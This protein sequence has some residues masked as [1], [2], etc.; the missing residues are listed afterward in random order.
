MRRQDPL[1][2][3]QLAVPV[4]VVKKAFELAQKTS[5]P[6][7]KATADLI[8]IAF[9]YMLRVGE[10]TKPRFT[11]VNGKRRKSSRTV[12]F[13]VQDVGFHKDTLVLDPLT[14]SEDLLVQCSSAT[15]RIGNQKNGRM[16]QTIH[17]DAIK[18]VDNG[19]TQAMAR[20]ISQI[21]ADG[22]T[23][24]SLLCDYK[25]TT[26]G[27]WLSI[28]AS[29]IIEMV[30]DTVKILKLHLNGI[31]PDL[32]GAHS[33]RAGGAVALKLHGISDTTIMKQGRWSGL[34][35]L[36]YIH[37]QIAHLSHDLSQKMSTELPFIN[38]AK[39]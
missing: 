20:R 35:F 28:T 9:Y 16:G 27:P 8:I 23:A 21:I 7:K 26:D 1:P 17:Q 22:G 31:D 39:F 10:Y 11:T 3:P 6:K 5:C 4:A 34:T 13:R 30:R 15:M 37:N 29:D 14:T 18:E 36:M 2:R 19:P 25:L 24:D 32:V 12:Q 33:L 38:I